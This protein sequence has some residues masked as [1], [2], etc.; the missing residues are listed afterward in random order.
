MGPQSMYGQYG[1]GMPN[2][3]MMGMPPMGFNVSHRGIFYYIVALLTVL[4]LISKTSIKVD[5]THTL[6]NKP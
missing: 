4:S 5:T 1:Y 3:N 6:N 2:V